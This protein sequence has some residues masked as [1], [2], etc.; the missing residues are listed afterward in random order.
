MK[1]TSQLNQGRRSMIQT[2]GYAREHQGVLRRGSRIR[3]LEANITNKLLTVAYKKI[4]L[5]D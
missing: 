1:Q 4:L 2:L 5:I 3:T